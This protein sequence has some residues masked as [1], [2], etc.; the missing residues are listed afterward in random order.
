MSQSTTIPRPV[1]DEHMNAAA[2][3]PGSAQT[4]PATQKPPLL[5]TS[6]P[7]TPASAGLLPGL[8]RAA[9]TSP[10]TDS[11]RHLRTRTAAASTWLGRRSRN[12]HRL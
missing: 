11:T 3:P 7:S 8:P 5:A 10:F 4:I 12:A 1:F 2:P 9:F 6:T